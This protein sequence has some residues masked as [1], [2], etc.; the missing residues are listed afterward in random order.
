M[1][2]HFIENGWACNLESL[3]PDFAGKNAICAFFWR[4]PIAI[5]RFSKGLSVTKCFRTWVSWQMHA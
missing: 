2:K 1:Q 3:S 4:E 5:T